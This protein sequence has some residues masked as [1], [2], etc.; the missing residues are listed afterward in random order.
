MMLSISSLQ[1]I[2]V[3]TSKFTS[4]LTGVVKLIFKIF[5]FY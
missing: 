1:F 2:D 3:D 5:R 4:K